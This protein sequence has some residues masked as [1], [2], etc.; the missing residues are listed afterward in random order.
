MILIRKTALKLNTEFIKLNSHTDIIVISVPHHHDLHSPTYV[1]NEIR[2]YTRNLFKVIQAFD[3][4]KFLELEFDCIFYMR[5]RLH[6]DKLGKAQLAK[7]ALYIQ[8]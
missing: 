2:K 1:N 6:F 4:T 5:R 8:Y 7:H 3:H